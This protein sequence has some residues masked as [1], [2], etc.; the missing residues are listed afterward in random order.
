MRLIVVL[1]FRSS[2]RE[3]E[4]MKTEENTIGSRIRKCRLAMGY[5]QE[6]L[7]ELLYMKKNT[8]CKYEK[9]EH[10]IP[11]TNIIALAKALNTTPNHLLLGETED[12][13]WMEDVMLILANIKDPAMRRIALNQLKY[14][15]DV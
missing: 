4:K 7:A 5:S 11:A 15:A 9:N 10:D 6:E 13:P 3:E 12:A 2:R 1:F 8:I 14:I